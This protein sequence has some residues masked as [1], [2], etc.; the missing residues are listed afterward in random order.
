MEISQISAYLFS[1]LVWDK[2]GIPLGQPVR[3]LEALGNGCFQLSRMQQYRD[4]GGM[5]RKGVEG[6]GEDGLL[7]HD[8]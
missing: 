4:L 3:D 6:S 2:R 7:D 8:R 5:I 1:S